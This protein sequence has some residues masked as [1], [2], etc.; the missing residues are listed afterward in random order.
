MIQPGVA[1]AVYVHYADAIRAID[2]YHNRQLDGRP[3][4]CEMVMNADSN[5]DYN[6]RY[7]SVFG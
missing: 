2:V 4:K 6:H 5:T 1:K 7:R 3:M